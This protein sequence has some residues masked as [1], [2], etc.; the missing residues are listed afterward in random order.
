MTELRSCP[1]HFS[2]AEKIEYKC[3]GNELN[4]KSHFR[5]TVF[6]FSSS[7]K[8]VYWRFQKQPTGLVMWLSGRT[9]A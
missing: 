7:L 1:Q 6:I 5:I 8:L 3:Q 4:C 9:F 2:L